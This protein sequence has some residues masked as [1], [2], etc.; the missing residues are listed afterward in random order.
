MREISVRQLC[1]PTHLW[2]I[3]QD[4]T[5]DVSFVMVK[6][7][8]DYSG[9]VQFEMISIGGMMIQYDGGKRVAITGPIADKAGYEGYVDESED[10]YVDVDWVTDLTEFTVAETSYVAYGNEPQVDCVGLAPFK[11]SYRPALT[12]RHQSPDVRQRRPS[13]A[14]RSAGR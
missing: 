2:V 10:N 9:H 4:I 11:V 7:I 6:D 3:Y 13:R 8:I 5:E 1:L 14:Y 12:S